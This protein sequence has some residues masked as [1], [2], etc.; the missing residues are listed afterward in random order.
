MF[1]IF[2][3]DSTSQYKS[4]TPHCIMLSCWTPLLIFDLTI[5]FCWWGDFT[6]TA[7]CHCRLSSEMFFSSLHLTSLSPLVQGPEIPAEVYCTF[8]ISC[9]TIYACT[10]PRENLQ[11]QQSAFLTLHI[12]VVLLMC[13]LTLMLLK[14]KICHWWEAIQRAIHKIYSDKNK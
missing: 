7:S 5:V 10:V 8:S 6:P 3:F 9:I 13:S 2:L 1:P 11:R 12:A 4:L 14:N